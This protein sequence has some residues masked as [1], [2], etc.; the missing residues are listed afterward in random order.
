M[1]AT[2]LESISIFSKLKTR[3]EA[4]TIKLNYIVLFAVI[5]PAQSNLGVDSIAPARRSFK[6]GYWSLGL[7]PT[8]Q[9]DGEDYRL[10][11][12]P[13]YSENAND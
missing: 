5:L 10:S 3:R 1:V 9:V 6:M 4:T 13:P 8:S 7:W 12:K 2:K 11:T